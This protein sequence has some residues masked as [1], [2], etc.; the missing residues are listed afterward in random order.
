MFL[1]LIKVLN[2]THNI[3]AVA[4]GPIH[5][6]AHT[7]QTE[8]HAQEAQQGE[9]EQVQRDG[10]HHEAREDA[11]EWLEQ[12]LHEPRDSPTLRDQGHGREDVVEVLKGDAWEVEVLVLKRAGGPLNGAVQH[13]YPETQRQT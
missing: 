13:Y 6:R 11:A 12:R 2:F 9:G 4:Q 5:A 8:R 10:V 3:I 1:L 7:A